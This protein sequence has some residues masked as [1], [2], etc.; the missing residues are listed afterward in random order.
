MS[1]CLK[2]VS[3]HVGDTVRFAPFWI[4]PFTHGT[5]TVR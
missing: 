2:G 4:Q 3:G 5:L 1:R